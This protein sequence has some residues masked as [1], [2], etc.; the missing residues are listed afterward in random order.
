MNATDEAHDLQ[1]PQAL[2]VQFNILNVVIGATMKA[3]AHYLLGNRIDGRK[4]V[5][6]NVKGFGRDLVSL[7]AV[8][9]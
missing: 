1:N 7:T 5:A 9:G 6:I 2:T 8:G 4:Y 3:R